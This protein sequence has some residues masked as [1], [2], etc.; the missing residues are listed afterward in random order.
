MY[1]VGKISASHVCK[2][3]CFK[4]CKNGEKICRS[5]FGDVGKEL[6]ELSIMNVDGVID[7]KRA[8]GFVNNFNW[9]IQVA[10]R[11]N[12]DI[13]SLFD[14]V[15]KTLAALYYITNYTTKMCISSYIQVLFARLAYLSVE[16]YNSVPSDSNDKV[17]KLM[18][19][20]LNAASNNTEY[21]G[22][23]VANMLLKNGVDG[24]HYC[25]DV[26]KTL[27]LHPILKLHNKNANILDNMMSIHT[28]LNIQAQEKTYISILIDYENRADELMSE[29]LYNFVSKYE[30]RKKTLASIC[31]SVR[32]KLKRYAF[33]DAHLH[34]IKK[35]T[36][37]R[38]EARKQIE[39][40]NFKFK[41]CLIMF[42]FL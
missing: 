15:S 24:T 8:D 14:K 31:E 27:N 1:E 23:L 7:L 10:G 28:V 21:S 29:C 19:S 30:K 34:A 12:H 5:G 22:A 18:S 17:K 3:T 26:I 11:C 2:P 6:R 36:T 40:L 42:F 41:F 38:R 39:C 13:K 9:I 33:K 16:K 35:T 20:C 4:Y 32:L 37:R 25:S